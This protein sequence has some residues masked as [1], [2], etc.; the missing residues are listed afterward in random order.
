M[1]QRFR[2]MRLLLRDDGTSLVAADALDPISGGNP[3]PGERA[4]AHTAYDAHDAPVFT[5]LGSGAW[6]RW[7]RFRPISYA[8]W[9]SR[10]SGSTCAVVMTSED[11]RRARRTCQGERAQGGSTITQQLARKSFD[12]RQAFR[13]SSRKRLVA[14]RGH[15][16]KDQILDFYLEPRT[17]ETGSTACRGA[18]I[19]GKSS[20]VT[21]T[22]RPSLRTHQG[23]VR[24]QPTVAHRATARCGG[25]TAM[26]DAGLTRQQPPTRGSP[27]RIRTASPPSV[28]AA[29]QESHHENS[30]RAI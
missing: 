24:L 17:S 28:P 15:F 23:A 11:R 2:A 9:R 18:R 10:T 16:T 8:R 13:G 14:D 29:F 5:T 19:L 22:K 7:R 21:S 30:G 12:G 6:C 1:A 4:S 20:L 25:S 3:Q 26:V 27:V